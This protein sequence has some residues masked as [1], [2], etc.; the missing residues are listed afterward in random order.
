[1]VHVLG[2]LI[3]RRLLL[4][5]HQVV[6]V[7]IGPKPAD[8]RPATEFLVVAIHDAVRGIAGADGRVETVGHG[9]LL[10][11]ASFPNERRCSRL[12]CDNFYQRN[13]RAGVMRGVSAR[14]TVAPTVARRPQIPVGGEH[15]PSASV[16]P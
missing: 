9:F 10:D 4:E 14:T 1:M 5:R 2:G 12:H 11:F 8:E 13:R 16:A 7:G 6:A 15:A 3:G